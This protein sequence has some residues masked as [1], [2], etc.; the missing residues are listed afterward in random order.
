MARG[1]DYRHPSAAR[2]GEQLLRE[3]QCLPGVLAAGAG[4]LAVDLAH[5]VVPAQIGLVVEVDGEHRGVVAD[6]GFAPIGL[7]DRDSVGVDDVFP[8]VI[9][10]IPRHGRFPPLVP[11]SIPFCRR[12]RLSTAGAMRRASAQAH[13]E[14]AAMPK[15]ESGK[16]RDRSAI[17][18]NESSKSCHNTTAGSRTIERGEGDP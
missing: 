4:K 14:P 5:R 18:I 9:L 3:R 12:P 15:R 11:Y 1:V 10:E 13:M 16:P 17:K 8:A 6:L 2:R 7:V